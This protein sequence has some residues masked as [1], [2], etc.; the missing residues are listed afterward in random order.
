MAAQAVASGI[1]VLTADLRILVT[2]LAAATALMLAAGT[3]VTGS[4]LLDWCGYT[5]P[6]RLVLWIFVLRLYLSTRE[7]QPVPAADGT[8]AQWGGAVARL[9]AG[10]AM[11]EIP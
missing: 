8:P 4:G 7:R 10:P 3:V 2:L 11:E 1:V 9:P 5:S 6:C